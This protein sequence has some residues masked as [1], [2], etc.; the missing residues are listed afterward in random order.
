VSEGATRPREAPAAARSRQFADAMRRARQGGA[1]DARGAAAR[2]AGSRA[3]QGRRAVADGKDAALAGRRDGSREEERLATAAAPV[4]AA[5][6]GPPATAA[7]GAPAA[8][9]LRAVIRAL[10]VAVDASRVRE[11][12]PLTLSLGRALDV[13]VRAG[14]EGVEVVLRPDPRLARVA[15]AEL[16]GLVASL[17]SRGIAVSR[18]EVRARAGDGGARV[19]VSTPLR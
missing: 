19:D 3:A 18:A 5:V 9:E 13:D 15:E 11:G 1:A 10:P 14:R 12:A 8:A 4:G 17:R 6:Q 7:A 16:P 2:E